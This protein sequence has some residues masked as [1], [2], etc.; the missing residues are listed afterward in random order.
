MD[1]P[2]SVASW[3]GGVDNQRTCQT[4]PNAKATRID[5]VIA[6]SHALPMVKGVQ[7]IKDDMIPTHSVV[8]VTLNRK[9]LSKEKRT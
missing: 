6:N 7:V 2:R 5:G 4:H 8:R 1:G 9:V 3:W